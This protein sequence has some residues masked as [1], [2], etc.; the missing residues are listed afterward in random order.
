MNF[1]RD[2]LERWQKEELASTSP[3]EGGSF[4]IG[5]PVKY[6]GVT[7]TIEKVVTE[8]DGT[9][10]LILSEEVTINGVYLKSID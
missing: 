8:E 3:S 9:L 10:T 5:K 1:V 2:L 7:S 4:L 6:K